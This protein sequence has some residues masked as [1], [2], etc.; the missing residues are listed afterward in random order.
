MALWASEQKGG[1]VYLIFVTTITAAG[2]AKFLVKPIFQLDSIGIS[3]TVEYFTH[4]ATIHKQCKILH[5]VLLQNNFC[6]KLTHFFEI[7]WPQIAA[8]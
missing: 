7:S 1:V 8:V 5:R 3:H 2:C 4:S 6:C